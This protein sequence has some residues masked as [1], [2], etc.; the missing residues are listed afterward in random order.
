MLE[1]LA[2]AL[3]VNAC[4]AVIETVEV[5]VQPINELTVTVYAVE[6]VIEVADGLAILVLFKKVDG[7]HTILFIG[8]LGGKKLNV[9]PDGIFAA[10]P[11]DEFSA[12][13]LAVLELAGERGVTLK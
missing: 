10:E 2:V 4:P 6:L 13:E 1:R 11:T 9:V 12:V 3:D 5:A 7:V 8:S